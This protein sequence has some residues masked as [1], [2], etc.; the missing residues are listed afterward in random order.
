MKFDVK[1][2][3][4]DLYQPRAGEIVEADVPL[5]R[6]LAIDGHGD[7]NSAPA[8]E[9]GLQALYSTAYAIKFAFRDRTGDDFVVG[10]LEGLWYADDPAVFASGEK[11]EWKW[12]I[13][14]PLPDAV[15]D[16]DATAGFGSAAAKKPDLPIAELRIQELREGRC[17]QVMHTGAYADEG[18]VIARLHARMEAAGLTWNGPHH[19]IYLSDPRRVAPDK[20]RTVLRQPVRPV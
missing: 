3:R 9:S 2:D 16:A 15:V 8:Y 11:S 4:K 20:L 13:M 19:E 6:F 17:L 14:L 12:T 10:P 18:P 1:K 5:M 7:P